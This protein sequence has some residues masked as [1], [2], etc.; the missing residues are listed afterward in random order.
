MVYSKEN[1]GCQMF[2]GE[3]H[4]PRGPTFTSEGG[5]ITSYY[6]NI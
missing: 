4:F 6:G 2:K 5:P 1:Y 3:S